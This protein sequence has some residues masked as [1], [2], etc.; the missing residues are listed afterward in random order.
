MS[1]D[2]RDESNIYYYI[3]FSRKE[4]VSAVAYPTRNNEND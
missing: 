4:K 2:E 3:E 1:D